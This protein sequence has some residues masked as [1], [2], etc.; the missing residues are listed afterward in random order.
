M[1]LIHDV[2]LEGSFLTWWSLLAAEVINIGENRV[3]CLS[4]SE[5]HGDSNPQSF[6]YCGDS[7]GAFFFRIVLDLREARTQL[8]KRST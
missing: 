5:A 3:G 8:A 2:F 1:I 4:N 7:A 6:R